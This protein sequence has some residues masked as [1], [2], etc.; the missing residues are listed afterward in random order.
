MLTNIFQ[1]APQ[2]VLRVKWLLFEELGGE[3]VR[4]HQYH[5]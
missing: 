5:S 3:N 4:Q 2:P 1:W